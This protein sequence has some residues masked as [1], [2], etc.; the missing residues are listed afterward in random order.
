MR[1]EFRGNDWKRAPISHEYVA[2]LESRIA[3]METFLSNLKA[4]SGQDRD[5]MI[6]AINFVDHL[7]SVHVA[8]DAIKHGGNVDHIDVSL[9][10]SWSRRG[11]GMT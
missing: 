7:P 10:S 2:A 6:D 5:A 8:A 4:A 1:C 9:R 3:A 11:D